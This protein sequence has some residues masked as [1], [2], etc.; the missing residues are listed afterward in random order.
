MADRFL[1]TVPNGDFVQPVAQCKRVMTDQDRANLIG[2]IMA[3][4]GRAK[5]RTQKR[6]PALFYKVD[7]DYGTWVAKGLGLE[8]GEIAALATISDDERTK[9]TAN[10][11][12][13]RGSPPE[14]RCAP[15]GGPV[16]RGLC[17]P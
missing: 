7:P 10:Q 3:Q 2:N 4:P 14:L 17:G 1:C 13:R 15:E 6:Q 8:V 9:T 16:L 11:G 5:E 12:T